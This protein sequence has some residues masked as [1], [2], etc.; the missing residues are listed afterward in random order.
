M[1]M[2]D[3][4]I[5]VENLSRRYLVGHQSS[6]N[7]RETHLR[8]VMSRTA[9]GLMRNTADLLRGR[10][11]VQG[12]KVEEFWALKDVTFEVNQGEVLGVIGR[13]GAGKST[14]LKILSRITEPSRGRIRIQGRVASLLEVGTGFHPE[15]T[16]RENIYL[17]AAILGITRSETRRKFDEIVS[18]AGVEKFI[19]TPVKRYSSGMYMRLAFAVAA[20]IEPEILLIDEVLAVGDL[21]FQK[22]CLGKM[23][24]VSQTDGRTIVFV[25]HQM[26]AVAALCSQV[27][28]L[29]DGRIVDKGKCLDVIRAYTFTT[30]K[31]TDLSFAPD[32]QRATITRVSLDR[33][34]IAQ[35]NLAVDIYF[36]SPYDLRPPVPGIVIASPD[37]IPIYGSNTRYH[38]ER[39]PS[40]PRRSGRFR[41]EAEHLPL[42]GGTYSLSVWLSEWQ[43]DHDCKE[44]I[45]QFDFPSRS[46]DAM[47]SSYNPGLLDWPAKWSVE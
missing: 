1:F 37:G 33:Q 11:I 46:L 39:Y 28:W 35:G 22:K 5:S 40:K 20:H 29:S 42:A 32:P 21:E 16:G 10:P 7:K 17:N 4:T 41:M 45:F 3:T 2:S 6:F 23:K 36:E 43:V 30:E 27:I 8:D 15:L 31:S 38:Q 24:S 19:D 34:A 47:R 13:N 9:R 44:Q 18:F 14:L 25:S 12:D 26:S